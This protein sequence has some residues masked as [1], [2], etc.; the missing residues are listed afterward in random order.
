MS[1]SPSTRRTR[2]GREGYV[3]DNVTAAPFVTNDI[4]HGRF[5]V[6]NCPDEMVIFARG[7][8]SIPL[9]FSPDVATMRQRMNMNSSMMMRHQLAAPN[10]VSRLLLPTRT[11]PRKRLTLTDSPPSST[12]HFTPPSSSMLP[13]KPNS[14]PPHSATPSPDAVKWSP[15]SKKCHFDTESNT[16]SA[17]PAVALKA[18]S[19]AQLLALLTEVMQSKPEIVP[20]VEKRLPQP[21]L[22]HLEE[23]LRYL[24]RNISRSLP[25]T[26]LE[27]KTDSMAYNRVCSHLVAFKKAVIDQVLF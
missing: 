7:R 27:S 17:D 23:R 22:P 21:D 18:L 13:I 14:C 4:E 11:S 19:K 24:K 5:T 26:R 9:T 12:I 15:V 3:L 16:E 25:N 1:M 6:D 10:A 8:R 2:R 20:E